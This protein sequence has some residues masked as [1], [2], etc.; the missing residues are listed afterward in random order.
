MSVSKFIVCPLNYRYD[1]RLLKNPPTRSL[2]LAS[3]A[4]FSHGEVA[5]DISI[6]Y[7]SVYAVRE[8]LALVKHSF[9]SFQHVGQFL[10]SQ[11]ENISRS[12]SLTA[13]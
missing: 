9:M 7:F 8:P 3:G 10:E 2:I 5:M 6:F 11:N 12:T 13:Y 1:R 4:Q